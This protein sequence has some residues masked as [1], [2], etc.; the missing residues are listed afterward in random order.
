MTVLFWNKILCAWGLVIV[1]LCGVSEIPANDIE[2]VCAL[3]APFWAHCVEVGMW[4]GNGWDKR[5]LGLKEPTQ[6]LSSV[7]LRLGAAESYAEGLPNISGNFLFGNFK[8][9]HFVIRLVEGKMPGWRET[10]DGWLLEPDSASLLISCL[11][12]WRQYVQWRYSARKSMV[13]AP[14]ARAAESRCVASTPLKDL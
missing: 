2:P 10:K 6:E 14:D 11:L 1:F 8:D 7:A 4:V 12:K 5:Q 3:Q 13:F 9:S